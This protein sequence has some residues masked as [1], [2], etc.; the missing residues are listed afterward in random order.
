MLKKSLEKDK[1]EPEPSVAM[2]TR[3][4]TSSEDSSS[5]DS[6]IIDENSEEDIDA[7]LEKN[8]AKC[9]LTAINVKNILHVS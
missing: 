2:V 7:K 5:H 3:M 8:A 4:V 9:N 6:W 1:I